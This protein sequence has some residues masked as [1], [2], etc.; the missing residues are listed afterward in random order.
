[1]GDKV[2]P[3]TYDGCWLAVCQM[4]R[5]LPYLSICLFLQVNSDAGGFYSCY[6]LTVLFHFEDKDWIIQE[7]KN[8]LVKVE[9]GQLLVRAMKSKCVTRAFSIEQALDLVRGNIISGNY[10]AVKM[11]PK[12]MAGKVPSLAMK[13][14][15]GKPHRVHIG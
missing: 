15:A 13:S 3:N 10:Q 6:I 2:I 11:P 9:G 8:R 4:V 1:M 7:G 14:S 5:H 12:T